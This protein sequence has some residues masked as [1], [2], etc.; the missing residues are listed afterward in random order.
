MNKFEK[1][2]SYKNCNNSEVDKVQKE[3]TIYQRIYYYFAN[4]ITTKNT[5]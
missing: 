3:K 4:F 2:R 1:P 5:Y